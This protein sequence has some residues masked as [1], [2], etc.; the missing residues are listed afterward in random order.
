MCISVC[1]N[2]GGRVKIFLSFSPRVLRMVPY[3]LLTP[4]RSL[5]AAVHVRHSGVIRGRFCSLDL[6]AISIR[7]LHRVA[8]SLNHERHVTLVVTATVTYALVHGAS[9]TI[10]AEL[11][12]VYSTDQCDVVADFCVVAQ[13]LDLSRLC[14]WLRQTWGNGFVVGTSICGEF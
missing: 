5:I 13:W 1:D 10:R 2:F 7:A 11:S 9:L 12:R 3:F 4:Y 8:I 6:A 14:C